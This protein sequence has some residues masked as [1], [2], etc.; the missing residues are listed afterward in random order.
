MGEPLS[1]GTFTCAAVIAAAGSGERLKVETGGIPKVFLKFQT[2]LGECSLLA[3]SVCAL[4]K[5]ELFSLIIIA[6]D[7]ARHQS[8][9]AELQEILGDT[10][11]IEFIQGGATRQETVFKGLQHL[12]NRTTHVA[13]HDAARPFVSSEALTEVVQKAYTSD[14]ALLV[15]PV[16]STLKRFSDGG[17][18]SATY[19]R[20]E[21]VLAQTPQ[22]FSCPLIFDAHQKALSE[23]YHATDDSELAERFGI[24]P[25]AVFN[26]SPNPKITEPKD[27]GIARNIA[28]RCK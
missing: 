26:D 24:S 11:M 22:V 8:Q 27:L 3:L 4:R 21:F 12:N 10:S 14:A 25:V 7:P 2:A 23:G 5:S 16:T 17:V 13:I 15:E 1:V 28:L 9:R 20:S 19:P 18:I 6:C